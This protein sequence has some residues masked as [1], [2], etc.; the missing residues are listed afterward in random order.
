[1]TFAVWISVMLSICTACPANKAMN[2]HGPSAVFLVEA[3]LSHAKS[4]LCTAGEI[5]ISWQH[6][7]KPT[8]A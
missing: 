4:L 8:V 6:I 2:P 7:S 3:L 5:R 1:M